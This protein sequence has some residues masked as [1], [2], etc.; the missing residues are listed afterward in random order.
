MTVNKIVC[1]ESKH[2]HCWRNARGRADQGRTQSKY[3]IL[4]NDWWSFIFT[5]IWGRNV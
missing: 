5:C 3:R 2:F 1:I 4:S